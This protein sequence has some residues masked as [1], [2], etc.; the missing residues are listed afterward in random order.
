MPSVWGVVHG[1]Y[2]DY[3]VC[4]I[5]DTEA[6]ATA[7][8][9]KANRMAQPKGMPYGYEVEEFPH[10]TQPMFLWQRDER[11]MK[12]WSMVF[13][14]HPARMYSSWQPIGTDRDEVEAMWLSKHPDTPT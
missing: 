11:G 5:Y 8:A 2:S 4:A 12:A 7:S 9:E 14:P 13:E 6:E 1:S 10:N 3:Q